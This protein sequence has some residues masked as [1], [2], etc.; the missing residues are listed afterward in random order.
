MLRGTVLLVGHVGDSI[1]HIG[2]LMDPN[3]AAE[4]ELIEKLNASVVERASRWAAHARA[5]TA[6]TCISAAFASR[7]GR[8][9][10]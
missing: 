1:F 10:H 5:N 7:G 4:R 3:D 2:Y 6:L 9:R 8:R